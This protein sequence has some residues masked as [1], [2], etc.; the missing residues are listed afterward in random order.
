MVKTM[1]VEDIQI[2]KNINNVLLLGD[3]QKSRRMVYAVCDGTLS[4]S[5]E[6]QA[7]KLDTYKG[8]VFYYKGLLPIYKMNERQKVTTGQMI[9]RFDKIPQGSMR[10]LLGVYFWAE[11]N[12]R[13]IDTLEILFHPE[14]YEPKPKT[15]TRKKESKQEQIDSVVNT[16]TE[17]SVES[18]NGVKEEEDA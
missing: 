9:G 16:V 2:F 11:K 13:I 15:R 14:R 7:W 5:K 17:V 4:F 12:G 6:K 18:Q 1:P 8:I 3:R 10:Y